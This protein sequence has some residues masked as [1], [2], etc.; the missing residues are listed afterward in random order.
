MAGTNK[1]TVNKLTR[2]R[3]KKHRRKEMMMIVGQCGCDAARQK[4][5]VSPRLVREFD[6]AGREYVVCVCVFRECV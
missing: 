4:L 2:E 5:C 3:R 6:D 1:P